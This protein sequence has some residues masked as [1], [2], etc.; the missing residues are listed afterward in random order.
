MTSGI[1]PKMQKFPINVT[2]LYES[3]I[4]PIRAKVNKIYGG[5]LSV[6]QYSYKY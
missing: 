4:L 3:S 1:K 5:S 2:V 6:A